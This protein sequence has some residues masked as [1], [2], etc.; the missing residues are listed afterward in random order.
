MLFVLMRR[1]R[2]HGTGATG[3]L[4]HSVCREHRLASTFLKGPDRPG[5]SVVAAVL[6]LLGRPR[7]DIEA[8]V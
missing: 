1:V 3:L 4:R 8:F 7:N 5:A 6:F 2:R